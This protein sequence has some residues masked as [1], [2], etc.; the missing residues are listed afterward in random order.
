MR[1]PASLT[2]ITRSTAEFLMGRLMLSSIALVLLLVL[3]WAFRYP[4]LR[5]TGTFLIKE[6][7]HARGDV[8]IVLGGAPVERGIAAAGLIKQGAAQQAVFTGSVIPQSVQ[9]AGLSSTEASLTRD[10]A[11]WAG[12]PPTDAHLLEIGTSTWEECVAVRDLALMSGYDTVVV[13]TTEFHTR[14]VGRVF[15]KV[16]GPSGIKVFV[17]AARATRY[18]AQHWW[19]TE[20]GLLMVNNEYVKLLYYAIK[21]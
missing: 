3:V 20:E 9:A 14:R 15:R 12:M 18:D 1:P 19:R 16:L 11:I 21:Y 6:D 7:P 10:I 5:I 4:L 8:L 2:R 17:R 13:V